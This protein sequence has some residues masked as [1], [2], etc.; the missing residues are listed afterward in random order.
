MEGE[1]IDSYFLKGI[2]AIGKGK[3]LCPEFE[4]GSPIPF[5]KLFGQTESD[6]PSCK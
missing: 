2:S 3:L 5:L 4:F 1:K 6:L